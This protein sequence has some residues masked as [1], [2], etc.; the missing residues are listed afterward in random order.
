M[1]K[2]TIIATAKNCYHAS[3]RAS[4]EAYEKPPVVDLI[5]M[6]FFDCVYAFLT[7]QIALRCEW[8]MFLS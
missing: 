7:G 3:R 5:I 8:I 1:D 6:R 2:D 4:V